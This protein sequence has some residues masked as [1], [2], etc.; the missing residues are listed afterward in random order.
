[1]EHFLPATSTSLGGRSII[2]SE[3]ALYRGGTRERASR[4]MTWSSVTWS[5]SS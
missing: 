5:K 2:T 4:S 1:M 3:S